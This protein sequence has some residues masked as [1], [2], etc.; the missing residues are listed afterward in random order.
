M[1][2]R[3]Y[4]QVRKDKEKLGYGYKLSWPR[5]SK[6]LHARLQGFSEEGNVPAA[7][8]SS[9]QQTSTPGTT[10]GEFDISGYYARSIGCSEI[11]SPSNRPPRSTITSPAATRRR[12]RPPRRIRERD[13]EPRSTNRER[14]PR[15]DKKR[16]SLSG[17]RPAPSLDR[18][19]IGSTKPK[20]SKR[21]SQSSNDNTEGVQNFAVRKS[22]SRR[23]PK[24]S[25][26]RAMT[27]STACSRTS[28]RSISTRR[29][30]LCVQADG[31][32]QMFGK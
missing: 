1:I 30:H 25:R 13:V 31:M 29:L 18:R 11:R 21:L 15:F 9:A 6:E 3:G 7:G 23:T 17:R 27:G 28:I 19:A 8:K 10:T 20:N 32:F 5:S 16:H 2:I 26:S 12:P 4:P 22:T 24:C 14:Q